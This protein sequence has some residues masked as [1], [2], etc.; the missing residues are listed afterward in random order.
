VERA[1]LVRVLLRE[2][3][4]VVAFASWV[5]FWMKSY[6]VVFISHGFL[7]ARRSGEGERRLP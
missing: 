2:E 5:R 1:R 6:A 7:L 3:V 4:R